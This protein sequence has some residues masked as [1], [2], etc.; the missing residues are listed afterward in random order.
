MVSVQ[1]TDVGSVWTE[2]EETSA[3]GELVIMSSVSLSAG[4][5]VTRDGETWERMPDLWSL[6]YDVTFDNGTYCAGAAMYPSARSS[7]GT[8]WTRPMLGWPSYG[9]ANRAGIYYA[10]SYQGGVF[11]SYDCLDWGPGAEPPLP[12]YSGSFDFN[13]RAI[14]VHKD[15][16]VLAGNDGAIYTAP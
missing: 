14:R 12:K 9:I 2:V 7:D 5:F 1:P 13:L 11:A 4:S 3:A 6:L 10:V 16:L 8:T 15:R